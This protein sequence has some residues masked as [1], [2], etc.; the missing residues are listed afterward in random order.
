MASG[1]AGPVT[2]TDTSAN[3][4]SQPVPTTF[5]YSSTRSSN[6]VTTDSIR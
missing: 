3:G 2:V 1:A 5:Q 6:G 4:T